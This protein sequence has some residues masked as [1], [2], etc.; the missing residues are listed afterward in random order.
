MDYFYYLLDSENYD[1]GT[2]KNI[3]IA[4]GSV[5]AVMTGGY[6]YNNIPAPTAEEI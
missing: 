4:A 1:D 5:F 2:Q 6:L 3:V